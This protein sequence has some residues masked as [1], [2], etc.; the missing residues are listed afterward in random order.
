M[1]KISRNAKDELTQ[2][3]R[4]KK[5][6]VVPQR[7]TTALALHFRALTLGPVGPALDRQAGQIDS[8]QG[9][10]EPLD[11]VWAPC[12][13]GVMD[14]PCGGWHYYRGI[15]MRLEPA[16]KRPPS[17]VVSGQIERVLSPS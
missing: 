1:T 6:S 10:N 11:L 15:A 3:S 5:K 13:P 2:L 16:P 14:P 17:A 7:L 4:S 12:F 9:V 8:H